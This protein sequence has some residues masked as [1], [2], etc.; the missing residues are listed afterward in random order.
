[1]AKKQMV[2]T[3]VEKQSVGHKIG[4][5]IL[6]VFLNAILW[7]FSFTCIFP[8]VWM[9]YS[10]LKEKREFNAN[11]IG[12]PENPDFQNYIDVLNSKDSDLI[13]AMGNSI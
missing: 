1:M 8:L 6:G 4:N 3:K 5:G 10:S 12:L 7:I 9:F 2:M 11:I 13:A